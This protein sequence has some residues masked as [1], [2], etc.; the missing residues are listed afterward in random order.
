VSDLGLASEIIGLTPPDQADPRWHPGTAARSRRREPGARRK[1][2]P[3]L[4]R[5]KVN[6]ILGARARQERA[7]K[8]FMS[9]AAR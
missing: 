9:L 8:H 3:I 2:D 7:I 5:H 6:V 4:E 1:P